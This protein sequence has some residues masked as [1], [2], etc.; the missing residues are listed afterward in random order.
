M[1][2]ETVEKAGFSNALKAA[3]G[4]DTGESLLQEALKFFEFRRIGKAFVMIGNGFAADHIHHILHDFLF[5]ERNRLCP[6]RHFGFG[7]ELN[8][9]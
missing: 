8:G 6:H 4:V 7:T 3:G 2:F 1:T 9:A 5:V